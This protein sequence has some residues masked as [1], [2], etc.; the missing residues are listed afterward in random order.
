MVTGR[1]RPPPVPDRGGAGA[2]GESGGAA[3]D[4]VGHGAAPVPTLML[5]YR[6]TVPCR[7]ER[8]DHVNAP[9]PQVPSPPT[10]REYLDA[11]LEPLATREALHDLR[12]ELGREIRDAKV[13]IIKWNI[14]TIVAVGALVWAI[15]A[16]LVG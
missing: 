6:L 11:R 13:E 12:A 2:I 14:G 7:L 9:E 10:W 3:V 4:P 15:M 16:R 5:R 8:I 1:R